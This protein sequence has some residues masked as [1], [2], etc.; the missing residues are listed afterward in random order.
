MTFDGDAVHRRKSSLV[1]TPKPK[2]QTG[3][4]PS[5]F[6][7]SLLDAQQKQNGLGTPNEDAIVANARPSDKDPDRAHEGERVQSRLL[8]KK[9]LSD[10]AFGIRE[11]AKKLAHIRLRLHVK[12]VFVLTKAYDEDLIKYTRDMTIW[13]LRVGQHNV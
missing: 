4:R 5:C 13:L 6:V 8:T 1:D 9:Q 2:L 11:L 7:H 3:R 12:N 10:M